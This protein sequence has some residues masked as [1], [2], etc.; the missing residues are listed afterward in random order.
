MLVLDV[1]RRI[2]RA[3]QAAPPLLPLTLASPLP[4]SPAA[5]P[6]SRSPLSVF[7]EAFD[8]MAEASEERSE[9]MVR[10]FGRARRLLRSGCGPDLKALLA[11]S[12][13]L[14]PFGPPD[15]GSSIN[16]MVAYVPLLVFAFEALDQVVLTI[17]C[18]TIVIISKI[19]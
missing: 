15:G 5:S 13:L 18:D 10:T 8:G 16:S 14:S 6:P 4:P 3:R 7:R 17:T 12:R 2:H 9:W 1:S 11:R 19:L